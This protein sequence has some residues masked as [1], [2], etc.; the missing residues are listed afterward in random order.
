MGEY[1]C[2]N[3]MNV[4]IIYDDLSNQ[5]VAYQQM[6]LLLRRPLGREAFPIDVFYLHSRLLYIATVQIIVRSK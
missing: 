2:D 6:S 1:F 3:G 4:L 5:V